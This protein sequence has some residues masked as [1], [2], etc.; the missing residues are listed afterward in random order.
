MAK[1]LTKL[2]K[3]RSQPASARRKLER[4]DQWTE[5]FAEY[6]Q[7]ECHLAEN[8]VAAYRRDLQRFET[9]RGNRP[10][11]GLKIS[12]LSDYVGWLS[13]QNLASSSIARHLVTL[14]MFFKYLQLEGV[15]RENL[16]ELLGSQK[17]WQRVPEVLSPIQIQRFLNRA[18]S[19]GKV[20]LARSRLIGKCCTRRVA[21][22]QK[23]PTCDWKIYTW[24]RATANAQAKGTSNGCRRSERQPLRRSN[25]ICSVCVQNW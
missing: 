7:R 3:L 19:I 13:D 14:K 8:T 23:F 12:Q 5:S 2:Q 20:L 22:S 18:A 16:A 4:L 9:W 11:T 21:V 24:I 1:R 10:I 6:L 25:F 17:L 15:L